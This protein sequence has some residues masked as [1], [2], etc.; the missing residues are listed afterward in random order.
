MIHIKGVTI[1]KD[2][3]S[4][5]LTG[6]ELY[7]L[8][9][10]LP[11]KGLV[12][13]KYPFLGLLAEEIEQRLEQAKRS[14]AEKGYLTILD[15]GKVIV[16]V[17]VAA[18]VGAAT[19]SRYMLIASR[20]PTSSGPN[21]RL[22]HAG[23][24]IAL[25]QENLSTNR[26]VLRGM[27]GIKT[28]QERLE[29]FFDLPEAAAATG[30]PFSLNEVD[31]SE[32]QHLALKEGK[33]ACRAFLSRAGIPFEAVDPLTIALA[34]DVG[35]SSLVVL[36]RSEQ[37]MRYGEQVAWLVGGQGVWYVQQGQAETVYLTPTTTAEIKQ[38]IARMV[39]TLYQEV[40]A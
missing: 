26:V 30:P 37:E 39:A 14:L 40:N 29:E 3:V 28:L 32:A 23:R 9:C 4:L 8:N 25:E 27:L 31:L 35:T 20:S 16:D 36:H 18:F 13:I 2:T 34:E 15:D 38:R 5:T 1:A 19:N 6:E 17:G 33:E 12:G 21:L 24:D 7:F 22:I 11:T 10:L